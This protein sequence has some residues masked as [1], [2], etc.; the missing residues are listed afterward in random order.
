[1]RTHAVGDEKEMAAVAPL[2][3]VASELNG[4]AVLIVTSPDA[5]IRQARVLDLIEACHPHP[6]GRWI[7]SLRRHFRLVP[8]CYTSAKSL[9]VGAALPVILLC[10][11]AFDLACLAAAGA[12]D[13]DAKST[14]DYRHR[15]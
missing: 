3:V 7:P 2:F 8:L 1:V 10:R 6:L 5:H 12:I 9:Q 15:P 14:F 11:I 13:L 4:V